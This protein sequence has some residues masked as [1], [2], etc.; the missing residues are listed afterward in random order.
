MTRDS[1]PRR[2]RLALVLG[3]AALLAAALAL[4]LTGPLLLSRTLFVLA[5]ANDLEPQRIEVERIGWNRLVLGDVLLGAEGQAAIRRILVTYTLPGL[6][7][8]RLEKVTAEG[9]L[10][11]G[12]ISQEGLSFGPLDRIIFG[13]G[14]AGLAY[15]AVALRSGRLEFASETGVARARFD[16]NLRRSDAGALGA[17]VNFFFQAGQT[18]F[19]GD[20]AVKKH[21]EALHV[22]A[23]LRAEDERILARLTLAPAGEK[24]GPVEREEGQDPGL[25]P[26]HDGLLEL[27]LDDFTLPHRVTNLSAKGTLRC[28]LEGAEAR[29]SSPRG[30]RLRVGALDHEFVQRLAPAKLIPYLPLESLALDLEATPE[31][32]P[33]AVLRKRGAGADLVIRGAARLGR[34]RSTALRVDVEGTGT[35]GT[36][37]LE[38]RRF[39]FSPLRLQV[40]GWRLASGRTLNGA[41]EVRLEGTPESFKGKL[42]LEASGEAAGPPEAARDVTETRIAGNI[43]SREGRFTLTLD[44]CGKLHISRLGLPGGISLS[45][46]LE[47]CVAPGPEPLLTLEHTQKEDRLARLRLE[48]A[49]APLSATQEART[50]SRR[51]IR[52]TT[53]R[54]RLEADAALAR[55][56]IRGRLSTSGGAVVAPELE[57]EIEG[58]AADLD[59]SLIEGRRSTAGPFAL[60]KFRSLGNRPWF[61]PLSLTGAVDTQGDQVNFTSRVT[62]E[63]GS[64][65]L[66]VKGS[67]SV[68]SGKGKARLTLTPLRFEP[69]ALQPG[70]LS[71]TLGRRVES[72]SG[73]VGASGSWAW[74]SAGLETPLDVQVE[75]FAFESRGASAEGINGAIHLDRSWPPRTPPA[76]RIE[77]DRVRAGIPL[78]DGDIRFQLKPNGH[79]AL[80]RITWRTLGGQIHG[81]GIVDPA[82]Q[83]RRMSFHVRDLQLAKLT[84]TLE[85]EGLSGTGALAGEI[86]LELVDNRLFVRNGR[87]TAGREGG[88]I[89]YRPSRRPSILATGG[90]GV[91]LLLE[92]MEDLRYEALRI[93]LDGEA[94]GDIK[95]GFHVRGANPAV[96]SGHPV[97]FNISVNG[98]LMELLRGMTVSS[99]ISDEVERDV[100]EKGL[101]R[102]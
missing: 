72:A 29:I 15:K 17:E 74:S 49:P 51:R 55:D 57:L 46:P 50:G 37:P 71:P 6:A 33:L 63:G 8:L 13:G 2:R 75:A 48:I 93:T 76:Q 42:L 66:N 19:S 101:R 64:L 92:M 99:R 32:A 67:H 95:L 3:A 9:I 88:T 86:P 14:G 41:L 40:K 28:S 80:E 21:D 54:L 60:S 77:I 79:L 5:E 89:T 39:D 98:L 16:G 52:G 94:V 43:A 69:G 11:Q 18:E 90:A 87:L 27:D 10:V 81:E 62:N 44:E 61:H 84:E 22:D 23:R 100:I 56:E 78:T 36:E 53:P 97:E 26:V 7:R 70:D 24:Q 20:V 83:S 31:G 35:F 68:V 91:D 65:D 58:I 25:W 34:G 96:H 85:L 1:S 12:K 38:V 4:W 45:K 30:L 73:S 102:R 47:L 82:A 59:W